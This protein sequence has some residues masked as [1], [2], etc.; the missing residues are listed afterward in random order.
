MTHYELMMIL[1]PSIG[2]KDI[3]TT[4]D[5][6]EKLLKDAG[7]KD[8]KTD[9]WGERKFA[10]KIKKSDTGYYI[11]WTMEL[12][13]E[14]IKSLNTQFNLDGNIWRYMFVNLED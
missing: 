8:I 13:G 7:A 6:V 4:I 10:Y 9:I 3:K 5:G 14:A 1:D 11:V 2:E 12:P